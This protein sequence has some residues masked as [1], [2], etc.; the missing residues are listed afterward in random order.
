MDKIK[1]LI[2]TANPM[3]VAEIGQVHDG[4]LGTAH[5]YVD[6]LIKIGGA[7]AIKFQV[8]FAEEES[9]FDDSFRVNF[10]YQ[11]QTRYDYWKRIEFDTKQWNSLFEKCKKITY[12]FLVLFF[13]RNQLIC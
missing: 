4:S 6:E 9:S 10:S 7:D 13:Q 5:R 3:I 1:K 11:D 8:H 12:C 2:N